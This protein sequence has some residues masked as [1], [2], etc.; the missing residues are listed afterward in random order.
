MTG[1]DTQWPRFQV[2]VQEKADSPH[3]DYGS[4]HA[5]D[6]E[7]ALLNARDVFVR[8]PECINIWVVPA[9]RI[10][11]K[12][13]EELELWRLESDDESGTGDSLESYQIFQKQRSAGTHQLVGQVEA[14]SPQAALAAALEKFQDTSPFSWWVF[15]SRMILKSR[16][17]DA[18]SMFAPARDKQFRMATD[19][20]THSAMRRIMKRT[21]DKA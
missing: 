4:V 17:E 3:L 9:D 1:A 16:A 21:E 6:Q 14:R 7:M 12:T 8:R 18:E 10:F 11:A 15:P 20:Q 5:P 13:A 19:F 2:F